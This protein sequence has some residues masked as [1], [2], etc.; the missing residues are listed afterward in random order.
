M[1]NDICTVLFADGGRCHRRRKYAG[2]GWCNTCYQW[3]RNNDGVDPN[4]R[5]RKR[6]WGQVLAELRAG[7]KATTDQCVMYS[8]HADRPSVDYQGTRMS[9]SRAVW[10]IAKGDP[11][12][13]HVLHTCHQGDEGCINIRHLYL[14]THL[15]NIQDAVD[16]GRTARG[17][18]NGT[19]KL[20]PE[21]VQEIRAM[22]AR[23]FS[24]RV[25][26]DRYGIK[27][28]AVSDIKTGKNWAW[29]PPE[30]RP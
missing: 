12:D 21:D 1:E 6:G 7:A 8:G 18:R 15:R 28:Q 3:S 30:P 13:A 26:G 5:K 14:G 19:N 22:L 29:L 27:Q 20:S 23:G 24:Q 16:A 4:G 17:Q 2:T 10:F 11:G 25:I 9:A